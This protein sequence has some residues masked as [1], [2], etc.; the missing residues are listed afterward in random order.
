M[1]QLF[2]KLKHLFPIAKI[3]IKTIPKI[4]ISM[5]DINAFFTP[6]QGRGKNDSNNSKRE[7]AVEL[8]LKGDV[9]NNWIQRSEKWK[10]LNS[11]CE[12]IMGGLTPEHTDKIQVSRKGGRKFNYDF[13]INFFQNGNITTTEKIEFKYNASSV[14]DCPQFASPMKLSQ[15]M[16]GISYEEFFYKNY[17]GLICEL[18][19][20]PK[21]TLTDYLKQIHN[22]KPKCVRNIQ[23]KYYKG[24]KG[25]SRYTGEAVDIEK[26]NQC[27]EITRESIKN[28]LT[29]AKLNAQKLSAYLKHSQDK[30]RYLMWKDSKMTLKSVNSDDYDII[31]VDEKI[32]NNNTIVAYIKSGCRLDILLRW[33]N[34]NGIAFP[35][36]Q[37]KSLGI[38]K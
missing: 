8:A 17:L 16:D 34:G 11:E 35:A 21:P 24:A 4:L 36:F 5:N 1:S 12:R 14:E 30:K 10:T 18:F 9:P 38:N 26:T 29:V 32:K 25:S 31:S 6:E 13:E 19:D 23:E 3:D 28:Y 27:K 2:L 7:L 22:N 20:E 37:I 15:Y 33:K